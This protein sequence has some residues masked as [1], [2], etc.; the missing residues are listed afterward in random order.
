MNYEHEP[1]NAV[2]RLTGLGDTLS[3]AKLWI[4]ALVSRLEHFTGC[5]SGSI[6]CPPRLALSKTGKF[7]FKVEGESASRVATCQCELGIKLPI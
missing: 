6:Q 3:L 5:A 1:F 4:L 2:T 7:P